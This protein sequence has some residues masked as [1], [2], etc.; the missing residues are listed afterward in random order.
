MS[1]KPSYTCEVETPNWPGATID[2]VLANGLDPGDVIWALRESRPVLDAPVNGTARRVIL[3]DGR[4]V[5]I[6]VWLEELDDDDQWTVI[7]AFEAGSIAQ[8]AWKNVFGW[9]D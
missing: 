1:D 5:L 4:R 2:R 9:E 8:A 6:E 3:R 7:N